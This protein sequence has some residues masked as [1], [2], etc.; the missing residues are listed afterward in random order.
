MPQGPGADLLYSALESQFA[1]IGVASV[2]VAMD[3]EPDLAFRERIARYG[4]A[5]WFL[6]QFD[7]TVS[8]AVCS[9]DVDF[10]LDLARDAPSAAEQA[11]YLAEAEA[12][13][14][15][16]SVYIPFGPP[17][18]WSMV[19]GGVAGFADNPWGLHPLF[20]LSGAPI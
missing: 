17:I 16:L 10:L 19:R 18:R 13:L 11:S 9:E 12:A 8:R 3:D 6:N 15:A 5:Q 2:R 20:P 4:G 7:C 1:A 14:V